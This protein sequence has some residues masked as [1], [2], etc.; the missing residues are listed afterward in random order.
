MNSFPMFLQ[1]KN[2]LREIVLNNDLLV[3]ILLPVY[4]GHKYLAEQLDSIFNQ[5]YK[6]IRVLIRDDMSNDN[7]L[8]IINEYYQRYPTQV[9]YFRGEANLGSSLSFAELLKYTSANFVMFCDQ[10]DV[11]LPNKVADSVNAIMDET[12]FISD[13]RCIYTDLIIVDQQLNIIHHSMRKI[14]K[15]TNESN[16][17]RDYLCLSRVTGCTMILNR[18][19]V[20]CL[21]LY[22]P[23]SRQIVH[24]HWYV[25]ILSIY[26]EVGFLNKQTILYRQHANNQVGVKK[27]TLTYLLR[28]VKSFIATYNYDMKINNN[29][30]EEFRISISQWFFRKI[31][32]NLIRLF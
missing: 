16:D 11:W 30:P 14:L 25:V 3:E 13:I 1:I 17:Y 20:N 27:I 23:P 4:N 8:D 7:S 10:D 26:G 9:I 24:D 31:K 12:L 21:S 6:D 15:I 22:P 5:T 2:D 32:L 28:K 19:A 18:A 29:L